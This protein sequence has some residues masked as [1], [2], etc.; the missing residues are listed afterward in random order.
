[1]ISSADGL[2]AALDTIPHLA[3]AD[4]TSP[5]TQPSFLVPAPALPQL[6]ETVPSEFEQPSVSPTR[7]LECHIIPPLWFSCPSPA[8]GG[9]VCLCGKVQLWLIRCVIAC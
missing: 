7:S 8:E 5:V 2:P 1:M 9:G 4:A 6:P 3:G